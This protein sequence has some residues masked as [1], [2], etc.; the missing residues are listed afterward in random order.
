MKLKSAVR[1]YIKDFTRPVII[2]YGV[3]VA[4]FIIQLIIVS[5]LHESDATGGMG[6]AA[7]IFLFVVGLNAFKAQFRLFLQNGLSRKTLYAGFVMGILVLSAALT[8]IDF[9][10]GRF[11]GLFLR[12]VSAFMDRFGSLY[13]NGNSL[14]AIAD[15]LLWTFLSYLSAGMLGFFLTSLYYRMNKALKLTV[16]VGVPVLF[17]IIIPLIDSLYTNGTITAFFL[18]IAA[19]AF[20]YGITLDASHGLLAGVMQQFFDMENGVALYPYRAMLFSAICATVT[21]LIS[22]LLIRRATVKE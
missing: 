16:S 22:F 6:P 12:Y 14:S 11:Q 13:A 18:N 15:G 3:L 17:T 7:T 9:A 4:L 20:G 19:F 2:F 8:V 1:F 5:L 10:F 21:A